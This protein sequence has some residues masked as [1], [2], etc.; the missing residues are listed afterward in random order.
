[1]VF[2]IPSSMHK[3][4]V[5]FSVNRYK[6]KENYISPHNL[7]F[8]ERHINH[9]VLKDYEAI[10]F[11]SVADFGCNHGACTVLA[12][13]NPNIHTITGIDLNTNA[14]QVAN[15]NLIENKEDPL[16][17]KKISFKEENLHTLKFNDNSFDNAFSFHTLEHIYPNDLE[18]VLCEIK[19]VLKPDGN[20]I[21]TVPY[22]HAYNDLSHV[23]YFNIKSI[24]NIFLEAGY[25]IIKCYRDQRIDKNNEKHDCLNLICKKPKSSL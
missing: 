23:S 5:R 15:L 9:L 6:L 12:A 22:E 21:I 25:T 20:F 13:R 7:A 24:S 4:K 14:I 11:G 2:K 17:I 1:M 19:R 10:L 16:V 3:L 18:K 8:W